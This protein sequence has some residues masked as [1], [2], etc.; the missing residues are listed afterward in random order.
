MAMS[1]TYCIEIVLFTRT[2]HNR[3]TSWKLSPRLQTDYRL[4]FDVNI[5]LRPDQTRPDQLVLRFYLFLYG[6]CT[7]HHY[8][9][10]P[11][12]SVKAEG[13]LWP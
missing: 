12:T 6:G 13:A 2:G 10:I 5:E 11:A 7:Q 4:H 9:Y 3:V 8:H 1:P